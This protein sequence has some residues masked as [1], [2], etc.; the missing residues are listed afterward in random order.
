MNEM[1]ERKQR[2]TP[3]SQ[4]LAVVAIVVV[5]CIALA[6]LALS[7]AFASASA[8]T[9]LPSVTATATEASY[10]EVNFAFGRGYIGDG[11]QVYFNQPDSDVDPSNYADGID[12]ALA[13]A[14]A[15]ARQSLD[16]AAFELNN[17]SIF[18]AILSA[19]ERGVAVRIVTDNEYGLRD[20]KD[21]HLRLLGAA[22]IP[23]VDDAR[24][25]LMHNK[26][27]ILDGAAV[28]TGSW[29]YTTN[30]TYRNNNNAI[31]IENAVIVAGYQ[32]EFEE[33]FTRGE[34]GSKS[35]DNGVVVARDGAAVAL[36]GV[37]AVSF[38]GREIDIIF[39]PEADETRILIDE[40]S[41]AEHSIRMMVFVFSLGDLADAILQQMVDPDFVVR[42]VFE[43]RNSKARWSQLPTLHCAGADMRQDGN[44]Y[45]LHH[46]VLIL[47][48]DTVI[49]GSFN[50][51]RNAAQSNDENIVI[52]RDAVIAGLYLDEW[53]R[54]WD[55]AER[56]EPGE[57]VC[58]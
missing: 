21:E 22:G 45:T 10:S 36:N 24:S 19:R 48:D 33:M 26:F 40:I 38:G 4:L 25:G 7:G 31:V 20:A 54:L 15:D 9:A 27:M 1:T 42:G 44:P 2:S 49:T 53:N 11:W 46:K 8:Q 6:Q 57:I 16:I 18:Q 17:E 39:A 52:V 50:F 58:D 14:I 3:K 28:W 29:N 12:V 35:A 43:N 37:T 13:N 5:V 51:S 55:S 32:V 47:D 30:G 41:Q 23:I 34:F 56:L